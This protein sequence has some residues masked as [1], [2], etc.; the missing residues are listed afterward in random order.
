LTLVREQCPE[1]TD[2]LLSVVVAA[3]RHEQFIEEL[4]A[5][6]NNAA[7]QDL[8]LI[9]IDDGSPDGTLARCQAYP[10]DERLPLRI[11]TKKNAG[12]VDSLRRGLELAR[13]RH[14]AFIGSDDLFCEGALARTCE[15]L[16]GDAGVPDALLCQAVLI[17]QNDGALA[18]GDEFQRLFLRDAASR[19]EVICTEFPKPMLIQATVFRTEFLRRLD[20]WDGKYELDDWPAFIRVFEAE[21][22]GRA[23]VRYDASLHLCYQRIHAGG[24]HTRLDR[25]LRVCEQVARSLVPPPLRR[26]CLA[27][28]RIDIGLIHLYQRQVSTGTLLVLRGL[29][30]CPTPAVFGRVF[31]RIARFVRKNVAAARS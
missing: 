4:L 16:K 27:N 9:V 30:H 1:R 12:L 5:S 31:R 21:A 20:I 8:E 7:S 13:G 10:Y 23:S 14:V 18:Y 15:T 6:V 24:I 26:R 28:V 3:Y 11:Y 25:Q 19:Y 17:G 29:A 22:G 2:P